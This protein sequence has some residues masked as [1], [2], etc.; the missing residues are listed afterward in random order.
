ML[1]IHS[2]MTVSRVTVHL[3][4]HPERSFRGFFP[5]SPVRQT[6]VPEVTSTKTWPLTNRS[7]SLASPLCRVSLPVNQCWRGTRGFPKFIEGAARTKRFG[8]DAK[9]ILGRVTRCSPGVSPLE[10]F[11]LV[12]AHEH[13][14]PSPLSNPHASVVT[15]SR[16][17]GVGVHLHL[18]GPSAGVGEPAR[19][20]SHLASLGDLV[21]LRAYANWEICHPTRFYW[22][23]LSGSRASARNGG[24]MVSR[25]PQK[26][27]RPFVLTDSRD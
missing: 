3:S 26:C 11:W 16:M 20:D 21:W 9:R 12:S 8:R 4:R 15:R 18:A 19:L 22:S 14:Q 13:V 27:W 25:P 23:G 6:R 17:G 10:A 7:T 1:L 5:L 24:M 2:P